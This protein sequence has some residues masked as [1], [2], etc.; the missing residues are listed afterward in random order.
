MNKVEPIC[1]PYREKISCFNPLE[2]IPHEF[3]SS[4]DNDIDCSYIF[5]P[6]YSLYVEEFIFLE[7]G[8]GPGPDNFVLLNDKPIKYYSELKWEFRRQTFWDSLEKNHAL[9]N[10]SVINRRPNECVKSLKV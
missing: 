8:P 4:G 9:R 10:E 1:R 2:E 5:P 6:G 7:D 3:L